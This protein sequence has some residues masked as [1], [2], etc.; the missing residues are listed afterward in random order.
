MGG[1]VARHAFDAHG[2]GPVRRDREI[3]HDVVEP[4]DLAHVGAERRV[5]RQ[6]EDAV[7][8]VAETELARRAQ[9]AFGDDPADLAAFDLEVAGQH[10]ADAR[11]R[12]DHPGLDVRRAAHDPQLTVAEIDVG[13]PDPIGVGVRDDVEDAGDDHAVH[14]AARFLDRLDLE[15]EL[16]QRVGDRV[17]LDV[18]ERRE[19]T[20]P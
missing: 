6:R 7:V 10:R 12:H 20:N 8:V 3:E 14:V 19:L 18:L 16:V 4:E 15:P 1:E 2:V 11:E 13:E 5:G 9:H 17:D